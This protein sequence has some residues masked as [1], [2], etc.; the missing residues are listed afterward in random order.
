MYMYVHVH[1]YVYVPSSPPSYFL[2]THVHVHCTYMCMYVYL[3]MVCA[4]FIEFGGGNLKF[5][6]DMEGEGVPWH[7]LSGGLPPSN[8]LKI[9]ALRFTP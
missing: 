2:P 8:V 6:I 7:S 5:G 4:E 9:D 1:V 3:K